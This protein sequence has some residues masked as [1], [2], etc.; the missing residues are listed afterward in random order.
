M[1]TIGGIQNEIRTLQAQLDK[2][3][4]SLAG[5]QN[6]LETIRQADAAG[7]PSEN[8]YETAKRNV[9]V[10]PFTGHPLAQEQAAK[11]SDRCF[12]ACLGKE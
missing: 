12:V 11:S 7:Q 1:P 3:Q 4:Q 8:Y 6:E 5:V 10:L 2:M 9:A